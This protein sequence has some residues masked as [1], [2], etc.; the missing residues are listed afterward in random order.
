MVENIIKIISAIVSLLMAVLQALQA[1][2][3]TVGAG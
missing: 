1:G 3:A 2:G